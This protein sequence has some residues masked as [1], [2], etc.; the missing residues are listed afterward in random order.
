MA[1]SVSDGGPPAKKRGVTART[2]NKW[3]AENDKALSMATW[4]VYDTVGREY[5]YAE[6]LHVYTFEDKL[7]SSRKF[8]PALIVG[9]KPPL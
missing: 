3:I 6:M 9:S 2:V 5:S 1:G 8:S 7:H 4:L